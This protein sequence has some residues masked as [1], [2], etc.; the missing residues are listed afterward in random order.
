M[1]WLLALIAIVCYDLTIIW[2]DADIT[3]ARCCMF[4]WAYADD[5]STYGGVLESDVRQHHIHSYKSLICDE[6]AIHCK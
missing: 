5:G 1:L 2:F 3:S 4:I 6:L